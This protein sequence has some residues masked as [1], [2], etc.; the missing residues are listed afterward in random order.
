MTTLATT[1]MSLPG[2]LQVLGEALYSTPDVAIR[3]LVQ[4]AHDSCVR[5]RI[6]DPAAAGGAVEA[7]IR[8][9]SDAARG[10]IHI[11]DTGAGLTASEVHDYLA[12]VGSGYTRFLRDATQDERM[13]GYFG[14]GFLS[15]YVVASRVQVWTCS[16]QNP[17]EPQL[18][19]SRG[20]EQ[21]SLSPGEVRPIGTEVRLEL[22]EEYAE[23]ASPGR[24]REILEHYCGLLDLPLFLDGEP[25]HTT[26]PWRD[27]AAHA[28]PLARKRRCLEFA[29]RF[30]PA[31]A[32]LATHLI[33]AGEAERIVEGLLWIQ[34]GGSYATSD[35]RHVSLFVRG[36]LI[37]DDERDLLPRWAGFFGAALE[38]AALKPTASRESLRKD[39]IYEAAKAQL[40]RE[41]IR[42]LLHV[43]QHEP[44]TWRAVRTR[45]NEA[46]LAACLCEP[47]LFAALADALLVPTSQGEFTLSALLQRTRGQIYLTQNDQHGA[48]EMLFRALRMPIVDGSR[49]A[50][51]P[52]CREYAAR[53]S[54]TVVELGTEAGDEVLFRPSGLDT[55]SEELLQGCFDAEQF[56]VLVRRFAPEFLPFV[57]VRDEDQHLKRRIE[58]DEANRRVAS[59]TLGLARL[60]TASVAPAAATKLYVNAANPIVQQLL[61][62]APEER[63]LMLALLAPLWVAHSADGGGADD[64]QTAYESAAKAF[65]GLFAVESTR[66]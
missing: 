51:A 8:V 53:R 34:D 18:F 46:L 17:G 9:T 47:E 39:H 62:V 59:A 10:W 21:Y 45:H 11:E 30:E 60:Y 27:G 66:P 23:L 64:A 37:G 48:Q 3:E 41:V 13:I 55:P 2:L 49:Y 26:P 57:A 22:K 63:A 43:A 44:E 20:G 15:A 31:F 52:F 50:V 5:R 12:T 1:R 29:A 14:L 40:E 42:A 28:S 4:N 58:S 24:L 54:G 36:M 38:S 61:C 25:I 56:Q 7:A 65:A 33:E 19:A 16:Y 35:H 32:P 6:E